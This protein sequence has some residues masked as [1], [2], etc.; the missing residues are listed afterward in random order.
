MSV[1]DAS[2]R[3]SRLSSALGAAGAPSAPVRAVFKAL[4]T[5]MIPGKEPA[6]LHSD[7]RQERDG[8]GTSLEKDVG[9]VFEGGGS[10]LPN[11]IPCRMLFANVE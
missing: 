1:L 3:K 10:V 5:E 7:L 6:T 4:A 2:M 8:I 9:L 11:Q